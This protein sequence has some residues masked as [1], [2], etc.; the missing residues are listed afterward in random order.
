R[1][2][3]Q[4]EAALFW[5][6]VVPPANFFPLVNQIARNVAVARGN[7]LVENARMFALLDLAL[8]DQAIACWDAKYTYNFLRPITAIQAADQGNA[9][10]EGDANWIPL[11]GPVGA[12]THPSYPSAHS[13]VMGTCAEVLARYFATDDIPFSISWF[14]LPGV[15]R[16]F[17]SFSQ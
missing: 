9:E 17:T 13:T 11:A 5:A 2:A 15:T 8:A 7:S 12:N 14:S 10:T 16:S 4:T 6:G 3:D 1:T